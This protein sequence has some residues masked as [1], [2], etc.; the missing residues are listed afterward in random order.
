[1]NMNDNRYVRDLIA[2][3]GELPPMPFVAERAL[4]LIRDPDSNMG[5]LAAVLALDQAM[6]TLVLRWANS[7]Y[8]GL[9]NP[10][11]TVQQAVV[12]LGMRTLHNLVLAASVAVWFD[13]PVPGYAL[14]RGSLWRH[15]LGTAAGAR[16]VAAPFGHAIAEEAYHAG[17]L[18]DIGKLAFEVLLRNIDAST[19]Q[20]QRKSFTELE[21]EHFGI[22]HAS[23]GGEMA[24]LWNLPMALIDAIAHH[25]EPEKAKEGHLLA[26]AVH[27]AD[28]AM[29]MCGIG[30]GKDGLQYT[31]SPTACEITQWNED[32]FSDLIAQVIPFINE[33]DQIIRM[34]RF[35]Q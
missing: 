30:I 13:R 33:A 6:A 3:I 16:L 26:A 12:Y 9:R 19:P 21:K 1:M 27:I 29:M 35:R 18:C 32:K 20:W 25:H 14:E 17:L 11:S 2:R 15:A 28:A 8:Y 5:D 34:R 23:L 24:R 7:A 22:D 4:A 31:L 10:V